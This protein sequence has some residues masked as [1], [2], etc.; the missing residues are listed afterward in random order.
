M[1]AVADLGTEYGVNA[2]AAAVL[3]EVPCIGSIVDVGDGKAAG[4]S[5]SAGGDEL[6]GGESAVA[7]GEECFTV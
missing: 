6:R 3:N 1:V 2:G 5:I 4:T 7:V